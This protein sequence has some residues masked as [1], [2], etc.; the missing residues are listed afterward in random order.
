MDDRAR[1]AYSCK[2]E[3][4]MKY[5][6]DGKYREFRG[7]VFANGKPTSITDRGTLEAIAKD[8]SFRRVDDE[9][10]NEETPK[11]VLGGCPKCGRVLS[12]GLTMHIKY[13]KG[14]Q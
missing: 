7:Y 9:K 8:S 14:K 6:F 3:S 1:H 4:G 2:K 11:A 12:R 13:C 10:E 5:I